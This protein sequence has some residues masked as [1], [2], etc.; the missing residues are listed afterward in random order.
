MKV[1]AHR[2][3]ISSVSEERL[4]GIGVAWQEGQQLMTLK[5]DNQKVGDE[6]APTVRLPNFCSEDLRTRM[7][8]TSRYAPSKRMRWSIVSISKSRQIVDQPE[9]LLENKVLKAES[10]KHST[11]T[12]TLLVELTHI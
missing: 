12:T 10:P 5:G 7:G 8:Y 11:H 4:Q 3:T 6:K 9:L 1:L 2:M